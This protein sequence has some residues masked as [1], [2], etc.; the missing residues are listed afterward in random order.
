MVLSL[1]AYTSHAGL[2]AALD[3]DRDQH[4]SADRFPPCTADV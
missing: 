4:R 3:E 1:Y 2:V